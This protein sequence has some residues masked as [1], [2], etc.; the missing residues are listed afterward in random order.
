MSDWKGIGT[1]FHMNKI[2][3]IFAQLTLGF[4]V[5]SLRI[6]LRNLEFIYF[7]IWKQGQER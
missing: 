6:R 1:T 2:D 3:L 7:K 4:V 5:N